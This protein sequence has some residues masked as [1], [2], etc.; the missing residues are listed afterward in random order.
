MAEILKQLHIKYANYYIKS[1]GYHNKN[2]SKYQ[3]KFKRKETIKVKGNNH[4]KIL[5]QENII[6]LH[7]IAVV[8][9]GKESNI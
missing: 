9:N 3:T 1:N 2:F 5:L 4:L 8:V 6:R 7:N